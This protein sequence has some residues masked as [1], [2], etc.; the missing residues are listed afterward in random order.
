M[1]TLI[2]SRMTTRGVVSK[3]VHAVNEQCVIKLDKE[4]CLRLIEALDN[5]PPANNKLRQ[6]FQTNFE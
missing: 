5:P 3:E 1:N 6:L 2:V 4:M